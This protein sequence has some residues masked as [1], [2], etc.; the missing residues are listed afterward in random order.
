MEAVRG[1]YAKTKAEASQ[2]VL[3]FARE[4][5]PAIIV[6]PSGIIGPYDDGRNH[7]VQLVRDYI[8]GKLPF[9]VKGGYD[10]ADVRD[11]ARGCLLAAEEG[12][13]GQS[14][15]LSGHYLSIQDLLLQVGEFCHKKPPRIVPMFLAKLVA[16]LIE[17]RASARG[18]RPLYTSYSLYTLMSNGNFENQ[19]A[20]TELGYSPRGIEETIRDMTNWLLA[21]RS[22]V[23]VAKRPKPCLSRV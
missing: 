8:D 13:A 9:C 15:I 14:Y 2:L 5:L 3:D 4:G 16:P 23:P 22:R 10:F 21:L 6:H 18:T 7:L 11:V 20:R 17:S 1:G 12:R 19:K